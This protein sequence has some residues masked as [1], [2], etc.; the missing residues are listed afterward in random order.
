M[1]LDLLNVLLLHSHI[2]IAYFALTAV[3]DGG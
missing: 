2:A 1:I 3:H